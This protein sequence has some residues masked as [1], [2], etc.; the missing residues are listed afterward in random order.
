MANM[1]RER[2]EVIRVP[3]EFKKWIQDLRRFKS[4]Q[5]KA[6]IKTSRIAKAMLNQYKK[7]PNLVNEIRFSKLSEK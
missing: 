5:E 1:N 3:S 4:E 2:T 7:Y 6:D